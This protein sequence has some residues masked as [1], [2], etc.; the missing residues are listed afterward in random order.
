[1]GDR[2]LDEREATKEV[3][4]CTSVLKCVS[5]QMCVCVNVFLCVC[6]RMLTCV[7]VCVP[8]VHVCARM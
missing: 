1:M 7:C 6:L 5:M 8:R 2:C 3:P 4:C